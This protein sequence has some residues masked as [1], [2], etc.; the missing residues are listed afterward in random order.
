M[1]YTKQEL[2]PLIYKDREDIDKFDIDNP[3]TLDAEMLRRMERSIIVNLDGA[4]KYILDIF[5]NAYYITTLIMMERH[6]VHYLSKYI[7]IAEHTSSAYYDIYKKNTNYKLF[8][9]IIMA[10]VN[11][12]IR[13]LDD[14]YLKYDNIFINHLNNYFN[15][16]GPFPEQD[17]KTAYQLYNYV[18]LNTDLKD[19]SIKRDIF[20]PRSIDYQAVSE[21]ES[22]L[23]YK[24]KS[25]WRTF[26]DDYNEKIIAE[27]LNFCENEHSASFLADHIRREAEGY[28]QKEVVEFIDKL[29]MKKLSTVHPQEE[30]AENK[31][32]WLEYKYNKLLQENEQLKRNLEAAH[33]EDWFS[34][35]EEQEEDKNGGKLSREKSALF[36]LSLANAFHFNYTNKKKDLAPVVN[37]LFGWGIAS[38]ERRLC[39]GSNKKNAEELAQI[40]DGLS[41]EL[42]RTI[43][44]KGVALPENEVTP[45]GD[46]PGDPK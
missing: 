38:S 8:S 3:Q 32:A 39:E 2:R 7:L 40:F 9:A 14:K 1:D 24:K 4:N 16:V 30:T 31:Y 46:P 36:V 43:R 44:N 19:Y 27:L 37:S 18:S 13:L 12:Y 5:N 22:L 21:M 17:V 35:E 42:S 11:N 41:P 6:P 10:M 33:S 26:T 25:T 29:D 20:K 34:V 28:N 45:P 15:E 23:Y